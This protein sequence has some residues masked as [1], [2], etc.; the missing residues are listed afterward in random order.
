MS[1]ERP[2]YNREKIAH[3]LDDIKKEEILKDSGVFDLFKELKNA[4]YIKR[5]DNP[6]TEKVLIG[7]NFWGRSQYETKTISDYTP[8]EIKRGTK[9][10]ISIFFNNTP[11]GCSEINIKI[12]DDLSLVLVRK[13][14]DGLS[15]VDEEKIKID[16]G[17]LDEV[18]AKEIHRCNKET[19]EKKERYH[20]IV[21][22]DGF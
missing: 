20:K 16:E 8:A 18:I 13:I 19:I 10:E 11:L 5:S 2:S 15:T 14:Y 22:D 12:E 17:K 9:G 6:V 4:G 1:S 21:R 7:K 3:Y